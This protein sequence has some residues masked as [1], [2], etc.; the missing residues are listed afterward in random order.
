M[1][2]NLVL[3]GGGARGIA[4]LGVVKS[5]LEHQIG[6][7]AI[8]G[9]SAGAIAGAFLAQGMTPDE[10]LEVAIENS[11][12][13]I[14]RPPFT[15]GFFSRSNMERVLEKYIPENSFSKL[16]IPLYVAATNINNACTEYFSSGEL[17]KPLIASSA[18][19]VL[20]S[21]IEING[22]QYLDGGLLNNLP[23][24][25]FLEDE[26]PLVGVHVNPVG[27]KE[28]LTTTLRIIERSIELA[29]YKNIQVRKSRC[30][31]F[32]EPE[33]LLPYSV[34]D[35]SNAKELFRIGYEYANE[36]IEKFLN[37]ETHQAGNF[38]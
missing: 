7:R 2:I 27:K 15:L 1:K 38:S 12:F 16:S 9:V 5:I 10:I 19:P 23:V 30:K 21:A 3:S 20:F 13:S 36:V 8:S 29:I 24:E 35:F 22:S 25:P 33:G 37:A 14:R 32:L 17:I 28:R 34:Y 18:L 6:I 26:G 31:L 4:H 11:D